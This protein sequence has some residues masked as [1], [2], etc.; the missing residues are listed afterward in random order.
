[1]RRKQR[2]GLKFVYEDPPL[3][4]ISQIL[5]NSLSNWSMNTATS[6]WWLLRNIDWD[7]MVNLCSESLLKI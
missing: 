1:M 3:K 6:L 7:V 5:H 2:G 4:I